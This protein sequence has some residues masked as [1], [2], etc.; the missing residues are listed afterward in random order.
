VKACGGLVDKIL[1]WASPGESPVEVN[2]KIEFVVNHKVALA[3]AAILLK[4]KSSQVWRGRAGT[5]PV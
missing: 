5:P 2:N 3:L 1:K 4:L